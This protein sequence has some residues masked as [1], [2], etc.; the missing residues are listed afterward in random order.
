MPATEERNNGPDRL[1][2]SLQPL[3]KSLALELLIYAPLVIIYF[4]LV[5]RYAG[6]YLTIFYQQNTTLY[7]VTALAAIVAQG[8]LLERLTTWLLHRFGLRK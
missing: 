7:A 4:L 1:D 8:V 5:L 6:R 3:L 2:P